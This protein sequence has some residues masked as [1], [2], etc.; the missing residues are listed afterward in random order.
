MGYRKL[1]AELHEKGLEKEA[2]RLSA[3]GA[4]RF[5][6]EILNLLTA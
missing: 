4:N 5:G 6:P 1:D 2:K 3:E